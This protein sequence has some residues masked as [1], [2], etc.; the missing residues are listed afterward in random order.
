MT[1][2]R[3]PPPLD[4]LHC[5]DA[6]VWIAKPSGMAVHR[7][8]ARDRITAIDVV[9]DLVGGPVH[10]VHRLDR[11]TSG[12][13][14]FA[15]SPEAARILGA[16]FAEGQIHKRYLALV[17]GIP[18]AP[19][20]VVDHPIERREDGPK[21]PA[22]TAWRVLAAVT[23]PGRY[24]LV[25]ARPETGRRHQIRRHMKHIDHPLIGDVKY[26]KGDHNRLFRDRFGLHRLALHAADL[27]LVHPLTGESV[28]RSAP[29]PDDLAD[30]LERLG[31]PSASW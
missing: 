17:R 12:V 25:E 13:M 19:E 1:A 20:G 2:T 6:L 21:V 3:P 24:A 9:R 10:T 14:V 31:I 30:P 16:A 29:V 11:A 15:R 22:R 7:G 8:D 5:D 18:R 27:G 28:H 4:L 26:G 23:S